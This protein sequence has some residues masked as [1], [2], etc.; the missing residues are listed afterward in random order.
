M[1]KRILTPE[2]ID[3]GS[4]YYTADEYNDCLR[5]LGRIGKFLGG[6]RATLQEFRALKE[7][8][9]SILDVGCGGGQFTIR[10]AKEYP[11]AFVKGIDISE[12]AIKF[13][14]EKLAEYS[15]SNIDFVIPA[16]PELNEPTKS[17]DVVTTTLVCHHLSDEQIVQFLKKS[18][19]VAKRAV[20]INDLQR[21]SLAY[22]LFSIIAPLFFPNR[23]ILHDG[24]LS[25][26]RSFTRQDWHSYLQQANIPARAYSISWHFAFRW[27]VTIYPEQIS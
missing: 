10:L 27:V 19:S 13:A 6:N 2:I 15:L 8:P 4:A 11:K 22:L 5:Q 20:I 17:Y 9:T 23:L 18:V 24:L 25:I 14:K 1:N 12:D 3:L 7:P 21:S 26:K 16:A